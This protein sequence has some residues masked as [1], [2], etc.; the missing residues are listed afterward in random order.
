MWS[1]FKGGTFKQIWMKQILLHIQALAF[2][3]FKFRLVRYCDIIRNTH[4]VVGPGCWPELLKLPCSAKRW[5]QQDRVPLYLILSLV[6]ETGTIKELKNRTWKVEGVYFAV[7]NK[8]LSDTLSLSAV[9]SKD[10]GSFL[11]WE[12]GIWWGSTAGTCR[13]LLPSSWP[14]R[15]RQT[16]LS[17]EVIN[18]INLIVIE[19]PH[20]HNNRNSKQ[21]Q[22][23]S[24]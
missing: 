3:R 10:K 1:S 6:P 15:W 7:K 16:P 8:L 13:S 17:P 21:C 2:Q 22:E 5:E 24:G 19:T 20:A 23:A 9:S 14:S 18:L 4:F 12:P 11:P